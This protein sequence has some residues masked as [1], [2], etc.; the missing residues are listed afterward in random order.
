MMTLNDLESQIQLNMRMSH[1]LADNVDT[2]LISPLY[3]CTT[4][5]HRY[6]YMGQ[7]PELKLMMMMMMIRCS[8]KCMI[9]ERAEKDAR[10]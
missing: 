3:S 6:L 8:V 5:T 9:S 4:D 1:G 10:S 2:S 7:V